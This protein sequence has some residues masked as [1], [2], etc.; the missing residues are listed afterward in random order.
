[1]QKTLRNSENLKR[2]LKKRSG[3]DCV[4]GVDTVAAQFQYRRLAHQVQA[5]QS[6][7]QVFDNIPFQP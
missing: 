2:M 5:M 4:F 7:A 6:L 3:F 1:M